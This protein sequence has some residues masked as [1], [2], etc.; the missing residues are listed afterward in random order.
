MET[1]NYSDDTDEFISKTPKTDKSREMMYNKYG[2]PAE[3][4]NYKGDL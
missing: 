1:I 3:R 2:T 4:K